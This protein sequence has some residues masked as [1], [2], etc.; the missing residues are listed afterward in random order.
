[1]PLTLTGEGL[2]IEEVAR[3]ARGR[4]PVALAAG[5]AERLLAS[6]AVV[7]EALASGAVVY[8]VNT[9]FGELK[10]RSIPPA[11]IAELQRNLLRSHA[12]GVGTPLP[13]EI[14]R[15]IGVL[16]AESLAIGVS[17]VRPEVVETLLA[18]LNAGVHPVIPEQGSVGA[19]GDLAP[20][21]HYALVLIGEGEAEYRGEAMSGGEALRRAGIAPLVLGPKEGL[22][23]INGTQQ[24][25]ATLSLALAD[26][27]ELLHAAV[28]A[29]ALSIEA[30]LGTA[31]A[32]D[33]RVQRARPHPGQ[34]WVAGA[35]RELLDGSEIMR[36][37]ADCER[38]QDPY[39]MRCAPQVIGAACDALAYVRAVCERELRSATDNPLVFPG[40]PNGARWSERVVSA[41]NFHAQPIALAADVGATAIATVASIAERRLDLLLDE[42]KSGLPAFL[43]SD[44]G[45]HSGWMLVQYTAAALVSENK[46]LCHPASVDS[47]PTSAGMED[48]VSMAPWAARKMRRVLENARRVVAAEYLLAAAALEHRFP[49]RPARGTGALFAA[50]RA[51]V[52]RLDADRPPSPDLE[53]LSRWLEGGG[54]RIAL[55][56]AGFALRSSFAP[57][58]APAVGKSR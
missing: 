26:A 30:L 39:S 7:D 48:H 35:L 37:H 32:F 10:N 1:M 36:S 49:L 27:E 45:L 4:E 19:S 21:A 56:A 18:T 43:A 29:A 33:E 50:V 57:A 22:A 31:V 55:A 54:A 58:E 11:K 41:G 2:T 5:V 28:G 38:I 6:R 20:L 44:P 24:S 53:R 52:A 34:A 3:V 47:I 9:G 40:A 25:T 12:A 42:K 14:V 8:G 46:T 16:R 17:G 23:L 15:A 51:L 13:A